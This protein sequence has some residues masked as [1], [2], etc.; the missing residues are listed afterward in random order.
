MSVLDKAWWQKISICKI[1]LNLIIQKAKL[2]RNRQDEIH[3]SRL[4]SA[5]LIV[6]CQIWENTASGE[7]CQ[8]YRDGAVIHVACLQASRLLIHLECT[9]HV[10]IHKYSPHL[11]LFL[12]A[13]F[14][15][16]LT[17]GFKCLEPRCCLWMGEVLRTAWNTDDLLA[18]RN[19][20]ILLLHG[21]TSSHF[22]I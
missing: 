14:L 15:Y 13:R 19:H 5:Q 10:F 16:Y 6:Q 21:L 18:N 8:H 2:K 12:R 9:L 7:L 11:L 1:N 22:R 17:W 3:S 20:V 4:P